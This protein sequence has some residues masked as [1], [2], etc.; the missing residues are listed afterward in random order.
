MTNDE[1]KSE[2]RRVGHN[3]LEV[4]D[5]DLKIEILLPAM[6]MILDSVIRAVCECE[7]D[8]VKLMALKYS[9]FKMFVEFQKGETT[10]VE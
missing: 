3:L 8:N 7:K 1:M 4:M 2:I 5:D 6:A 9:F 10:Y